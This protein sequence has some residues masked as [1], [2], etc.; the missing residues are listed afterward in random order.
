MSDDRP[1]GVSLENRLMSD[2]IYVLSIE[3]GDDPGG[4]ERD[5]SSRSDAVGARDGVRMS[6]EYEVVSDAP[7]VTSDEV[8]TVVRTVLAIADEREWSPG[9]LSVTS[10]TT[11]GDVRGRWHVERAWF[12][13]LSA[14]LSEH[15]F[16]R[17]VLET[18]TA[19][20]DEE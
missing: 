7:R 13:G 10:R 5:G 9:R 4:G 12:D 17:R 16:S 11:G 3:W 18:V 15:E 1:I 14:E 6:L 8:G 19:G 2:G 20:S